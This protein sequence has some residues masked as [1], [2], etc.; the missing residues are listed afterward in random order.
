MKTT[1]DILEEIIRK[2]V[3]LEEIE[4]GETEKKVKIIIKTQTSERV[5]FSKR[6]LTMKMIEEITKCKI[7]FGLERQGNDIKIRVEEPEREWMEAC[8]S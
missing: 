3:R 2:H 7:V 5:I 8:L 1:G 6:G 4:E